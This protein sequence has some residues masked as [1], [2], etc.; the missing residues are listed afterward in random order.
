MGLQNYVGEII[1]AMAGVAG[2]IFAWFSGRKH[3]ETLIKKSEAEAV[4]NELMN[5]NLVRDTEKGLV[6][7]MKF[8]I[9]ELTVLNNDLRAVI[10]QKDED[11]KSVLKEK[12]TVIEKYRLIIE[13]QKLQ[14]NKYQH[15]LA[16]C[17]MEL[18]VFKSNKNGN[19]AQ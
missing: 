17:S 6:E 1:A 14:I 15:E 18:D 8:H 11:L 19:K 10:K 9:K 16:I 7:D 4:N 12:D 2:S 13:Q 3:Q 5:L